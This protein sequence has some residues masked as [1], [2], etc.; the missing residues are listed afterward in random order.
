MLNFQSQRIRCREEDIELSHDVSP[1]R[2]DPKSW[3][4]L[5]ISS[6]GCPESFTCSV[7]CQ[8]IFVAEAHRKYCVH[9]HA[10]V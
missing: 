4:P 7:I 8:M 9:D 6:T 3:R 2:V 10:P 5:Y 1:M